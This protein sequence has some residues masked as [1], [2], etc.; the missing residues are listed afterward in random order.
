MLLSGN[1]H[2]GSFVSSAALLH[3]WLMVNFKIFWPHYNTY[4]R[5]QQIILMRWLSFY[6]NS[7]VI[8]EM[9]RWYK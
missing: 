8:N 1:V 7:W 3:H 9:V 4:C 5:L 2:D 6:M